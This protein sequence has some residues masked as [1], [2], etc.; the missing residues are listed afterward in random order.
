MKKAIIVGA[1]SGI[2]RELAK[3]LASHEYDVGITARRVELLNDLAKVLPTKTYI[4]KMDLLD[5]D[6]A[7]HILDDLLSEMAD[8]DLIILYACT[9]HVNSTLD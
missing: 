1:S 7:I 8:V 2:G 4:R 9:G 3:V 6:S 5:T